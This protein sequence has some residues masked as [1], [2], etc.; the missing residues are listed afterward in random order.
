MLI[1]GY[2]AF[3]CHLLDDMDTIFSVGHTMDDL[4]HLSLY[5]SLNPTL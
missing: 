4:N 5:R 1:R 3:F 2:N